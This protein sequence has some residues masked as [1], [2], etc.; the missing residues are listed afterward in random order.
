MQGKISVGIVGPFNQIAADFGFVATA[1]ET[2]IAHLSGTWE[3][4]QDNLKGGEPEL[5]IVYAEASPSPSALADTL[6]RLKRAVAIVLMPPQ[7]ADMVGQIEQIHTVRKVYVMPVAPAEVVRFGLTAVRTER[8]RTASAAPLM[9]ASTGGRAANVVGTRVMAFV[10]AEGGVG[11]STIAEALGFEL[12]ARRGIK[13]L[14]FSLDLPPAAML[15]FAPAGG[16]RKTLG[17]TPNATE[18]LVR[19][20]VGFQ[21]SIQTTVDGLD[22]IMA[23]S[24]SFAYADWAQPEKADLLRQMVAASFMHHYGA[25]L[26]DLPAGEGAWTIQPLLAANTI[27]IV[28]RPTLR[29]VQAVAHTTRLLTEELVGQHQVPRESIYVILNQR[30]KKSFTPDYFQ[31][32]GATYAETYGG[33]FP[34]VI[35]TADYDE[36]IPAAQ[37][38]QRPV[39]NVSDTMAKLVSHLADSIYGQGYRGDK[40]AQVKRGPFGIRIKVR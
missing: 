23:P 17:A 12:A 35:A 40:P 18:Y 30:T 4:F 24:S 39:V 1:E 27:F 6:S 7:W 13:T 2:R 38:T 19:P 22:V 16:K 26:L 31:S 21:D 10:A 25:V 33:W 37:D 15:H 29:G 28:A 34:P 9:A 20:E 14:L 11:K 5:V 36:E 8:A 32:E 3:Q